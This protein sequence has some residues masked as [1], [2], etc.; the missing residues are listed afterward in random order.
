MFRPFVDKT[1]PLDVGSG[2][3]LGTWCPVLY[4]LGDGH[5]PSLTIGAEDAAGGTYAPCHSGELAKL[6]VSLFSSKT[7][8]VLPL[9][10]VERVIVPDSPRNLC[11]RYFVLIL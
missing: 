5:P 2:I 11:H 6:G 3:V 8:P 4:Y 1:H 7:T 9:S 10:N